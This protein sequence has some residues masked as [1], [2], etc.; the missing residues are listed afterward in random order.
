MTL[1]NKIP[2]QI[3]FR[4]RKNL[5]LFKVKIYSTQ[6]NHSYAIETIYTQVNKDRKSSLVNIC[7]FADA[8]INFKITISFK[9][10]GTA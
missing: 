5:M 7:Y 2:Q 6:C 9:I 4:K 1:Q 10:G 8:K 3:V